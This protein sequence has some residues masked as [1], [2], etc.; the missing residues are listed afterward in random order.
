[1][2]AGEWDESEGGLEQG[3]ETAARPAAGE[4]AAREQIKERE[5]K[6]KTEEERN[7]SASKCRG[8]E[9]KKDNNSNLY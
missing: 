9:Q 4:K 8:K 3:Q 7:A 6:K 2:T 5:R 1:M